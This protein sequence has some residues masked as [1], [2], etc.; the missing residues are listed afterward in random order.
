MVL[1]A[2]RVRAQGCKDVIAPT[3]CTLASLGP[4]PIRIRTCAGV[5]PHVPPQTSLPGNDPTGSI[6]RGVGDLWGKFENKF[7]ASF[8]VKSEVNPGFENEA[9]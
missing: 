9:G 5:S 6:K 4:T 2:A 3:L 1:A 7:W 8:H